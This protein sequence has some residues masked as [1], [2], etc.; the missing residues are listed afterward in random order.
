[1]SLLLAE[2]LAL[3]LGPHGVTL[4][5]GPARAEVLS[6]DTLAAALDALPEAA[7]PKRARLEVTVANAWVR[8]QVVDMPSGVTGRDERAA[9]VRARMAEVFGSSAQAWVSAWDERPAARVLASALDVVL[10]QRLQAWAAARGLKLA[11]VQPAWLRGYAALRGD[12]PLGG[13]AQ[14]QHGWLCMGLWSG[15]QWLHMRGEAL[16][17]PAGLGALLERR[18]NL[19]DG[20]LAG[21]R[22]F[23]QGA[24]AVSLP[25]GWQCV[26]GVVQ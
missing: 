26:A 17:D 15:G 2:S 14:W 16:T 21:G 6:L 22:L 20:E 18:L 8:W 13:F 1:M 24:P 5:G 12:A 7:T 3:E 19:F 10:M 11:S 4:K 23:L 25:R 9:L